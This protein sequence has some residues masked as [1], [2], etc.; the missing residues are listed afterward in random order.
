MNRRKR[1]RRRSIAAGERRC[2][3]C[4]A[5]LQGAY[6]SDCG[7]AARTDRLAVSEALQHAV[8]GF[9]GIERALPRTLVGLSLDP[10]GT[11]AR[12]VEGRRIRYIAPLRYAAWTVGLYV[13]A[14]RWLGI[15]PIE[16]TATADEP[17][18]SREFL[19]Q[20]LPKVRGAWEL[21][22]L[23][24]LPAVALVQRVL[25]ARSG[26]NYAEGLAFLLYACGHAYL[27]ALLALPLA[28]AAPRAES[29]ARLAVT[30]AYLTWA[31]RGFFGGSSWLALPKVLAL[32]AAELV[33]IL[34]ILLIVLMPLIRA[35][36]APT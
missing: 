8:G 27:L 24:S 21:A 23:V 25:F 26:R 9:T 6:C 34:A 22:V 36:S 10:G 2:R 32:L 16:L 31:A 29:A 13:L 14:I 20:A 17:E 12:Y 33:A 7:Q 18:R 3:N 19:E 4:G 1:A 5:P 35:M 30:V 11:V 28:L 15:D